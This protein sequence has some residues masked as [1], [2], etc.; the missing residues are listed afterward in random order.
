MAIVAADWTVDRQTGN[1]RYIGNDHN[2]AAPSYATVI[3]LH[4]WLQG[5]ADDPTS[6]G[7]DELDM[8]DVLP[9]SRATDNLITL[10]GSYNIDDGA[11]EHLYDGS[12]VQ[13]TGGTEAYYDGIVNFGNLGVVVQIH[14]NG[15]V[16]ADDFWNWGVG[17][18]DDTST[19]AAFLTDSGESWTTDQWVGYVIKNTTDGSQA[20]ITANTGTTITGTLYGGTENDW[21]SGDA[22]LISKGLNADAAQGISHRFLM[23]VRTAGADTDGRRLLGIS[24][25]YG[26]TYSEFKINGTARGNNVLALSDAND[27]NNATAYATVAAYADVFIDRVDSTANA[28]GTNAAGQNVLNVGVGEGTNFA[29]GDFIMI[30]NQNHEYKIVSIATDALT[31]NRNL[32]VAA[33]ASEDVYDLNIGF[34]QI[35]VDDNASTEDYYAEWDRGAQTINAFYEYTKYLSADATVHYIYGI[36]GDLFRGITHQ[37]AL[38]GTVTGNFDGVEG[39][40]WTAG[41]GGSVGTGQMLAITSETGSPTAMWVQLLTGGTPGTS[42]VITGDNSGATVSTHASTAVVD[43]SSLIAKPFV[44]QSTGSALIGSYGLTLQKLDLAST[45]KVFDLTNTQITPPNTVT[46]KVNGP[47][48]A[49]EDY[50]LVGPWDGSS[51]DVNGDP[52]INYNQMGLNTALTTDNI[53]AVVIGNASGDV[54]TESTQPQ[55]EVEQPA[56]EQVSSPETEGG[57]VNG[58]NPPKV[59]PYPRFKEVNDKYRA[60]EQSAKQRAEELAAEQLFR[61][62]ED[63]PEM[64][65]WIYGNEGAHTQGQPTLAPS[66]AQSAPAP[67]PTVATP[68]APQVQAPKQDAEPEWATR[69][70]QLERAYADMQRRTHIDSVA[71]A[72]DQEMGKYDVFKEE[73]ASKFG[74]K[75]ILATMSVNPYL[76]AHQVVK[77]IV[78][79]MNGYEESIKKSYIQ[80]KESS[81]GLPAKGAG[82]LPPTITPQEVN[83]SDGSA[84]KAFAQMVGEDV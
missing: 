41:T 27:L 47:A 45:D 55:P 19:N 70:S 65:K 23:K 51:T 5:L 1:I 75:L 81:N 29:D 46:F 63:N 84:L 61:L 17:G 9:S 12:I 68:Q 76:P 25:T 66:P 42:A 28:S 44:G 49:S 53:T 79:E 2:G 60:L 58:A 50:V 36:P 20:L 22:Y 7:D 31:L 40:S 39:V 15:A 32:E 73:A 3:E 14:Q 11:A 37:F 67:T 6:S 34:R 24:R 74:E 57:D 4:R 64:A 10:L 56:V 71:S 52:E 82:G 83:L 18:T 43:R 21:D 33:S 54:T 16:L 78:T 48:T 59:I 62:A 69:V 26:R 38:T 77:D 13:G 72:I 30:S 8:T 35:D 80:G